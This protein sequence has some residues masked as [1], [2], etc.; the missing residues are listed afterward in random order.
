MDVNENNLLAVMVPESKDVVFG[1]LKDTVGVVFLKDRVISNRMPFGALK[2]SK[3]NFDVTLYKDFQAEAL[4]GK[5][6]FINYSG[7]NWELKL[8]EDAVQMVDILNKLKKAILEENSK[9]KPV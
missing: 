9:Y 7:I 1:E 8:P 6:T 2:K 5:N 3:M 4:M